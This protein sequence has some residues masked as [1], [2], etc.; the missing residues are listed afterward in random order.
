MTNE[1]QGQG[2]DLVVVYRAPDEYV[3]NVIKGLLVGEDIP[4]VLE[5]RQVPWMDGVMKMGEGYWGDVVVP[6]E[7]ADKAREI[8]QAYQAVDETQT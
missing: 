2:E 1:I 5:S 8:I 6:R 3:A 7:Y 4:V